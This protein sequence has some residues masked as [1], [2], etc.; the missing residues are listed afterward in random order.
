MLSPD[1][2]EISR[3]YPKLPV[4]IKQSIKVLIKALQKQGRK[5]GIL[6]NQLRFW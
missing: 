6:C 4:H 2:A 5:G 1:I 3:L